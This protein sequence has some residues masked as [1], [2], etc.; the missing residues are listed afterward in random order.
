MFDYVKQ[1][2]EEEEKE[3]RKLTE[4]ERKNLLDKNNFPSLSQSYNH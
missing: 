1:R 3:E 2:E 4:Q